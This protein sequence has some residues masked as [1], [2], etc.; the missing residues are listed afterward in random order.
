MEIY[1]Y[2]EEDNTTMTLDY[3][4]GV[5]ISNREGKRQ[6]DIVKDKVSYLMDKYM[7]R[8]NNII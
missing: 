1:E 2:L 4:H 5:T 6:R 7:Q 3:K 8:I